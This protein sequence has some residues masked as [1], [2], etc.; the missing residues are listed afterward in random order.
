MNFLNSSV[1]STQ[2]F[3]DKSVKMLFEQ[4]I[5]GTK[6]RDI[7]CAET[8]FERLSGQRPS[9]RQRNIPTIFLRNRTSQYFHKPRLWKYLKDIPGRESSPLAYFHVT[10][11]LVD[12]ITT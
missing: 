4:E 11:S 2:L 5:V 10:H 1:C 12:C 9:M 6:N 7:S 3:E 8:I